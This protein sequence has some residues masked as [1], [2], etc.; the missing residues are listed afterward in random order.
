MVTGKR[1]KLSGGNMSRLTKKRNLIYKDA[2]AASETIHRLLKHV[3]KE[4]IT[5][6]PESYGINEDNEHVLSYIK[7]TVPAGSPS[8]LWNVGILKDAAGKLRQWHDATAAFPLDSSRWLME[9]D[10][11]NEVV[12]HCDF[13]PYNTV[14]RRKK[15][16]GIIDFDVCSPGSRLW[17]IC[18]AAYRFIPLFPSE[19]VNP[20]WDIS[21]FSRDEMKD[22]LLIFLNTYSHDKPDRLYSPDEVILKLKKRLTV[23]SEWSTEYGRM[24]NN[25]EMREHAEMYKNHSEWIEELC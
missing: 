7:G 10:E 21:P 1:K 22:R 17:D 11:P 19:S 13:A 9:N 16:A 20:K 3:R 2:S 4:G 12:C 25:P 15:I 8:W 23:L 6:V 14:F 5:W 18:Y 24:N